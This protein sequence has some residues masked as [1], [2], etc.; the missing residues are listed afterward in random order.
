MLYLYMMMI[1]FSFTKI[2]IFLRYVVL[3]LLFLLGFQAYAAAFSGVVIKV[4][5][6]DT[7]QVRAAGG[8]VTKIRLYGIDC[9]ETTQSYGKSAARYVEKAAL[10]RSVN[11]KVIETDQY[12]RQ[13][14]IVTVKNEQTS[15]NAQL[16]RQ[17]YAWYYPQYCRS[18]DFCKN[19]KSLEHAAR[20]QKL[21]L[22]QDPDT[23]PP[24]EYRRN[25]KN[26]GNNSEFNWE[27]NISEIGEFLKQFFRRVKRFVFNFMELL[28]E[29]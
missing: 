19:L 10:N 24:W 29:D 25:A 1:M 15:L 22:W 28:V 12:G 16:V 27:E 26:N 9:P 7:I 14:A 20:K 11:V 3:L 4:S 21:G 23:T 18:G 2:K 8:G 5:D 6:G 13:V 17:G